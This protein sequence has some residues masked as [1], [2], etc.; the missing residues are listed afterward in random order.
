MKI[1]TVDGWNNFCRVFELPERFSNKFC[2]DG[3][4][5]TNFQMVDWFN[6]IPDMPSPGVT[7]EVWKEEVGE[8]ETAEVSIED[9][10][11]NIVPFLKEKVYMKKGRTY[12]ILFDFGTAITFE[13]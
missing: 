5:P 10:E 3:G 7:K 9:L 13:A 12:L 8:I 1:F 6:P 2:F 11:D 4:I